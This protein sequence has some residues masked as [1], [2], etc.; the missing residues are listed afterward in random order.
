MAAPASITYKVT[1]V[2]PE[3]RYTPTATP[4]PGK[5]VTFTT[6]TG[7]EGS[8]FAPDTVFGDLDAVRQLVEGEVRTVAAAQ[9]ITGSL[10]GT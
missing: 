10:N 3:T 5:R 9:A 2:T 6:S 7:Y 1:G 4:V 8:V